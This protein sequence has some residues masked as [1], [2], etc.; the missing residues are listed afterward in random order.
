MSVRQVMYFQLGGREIDEGVEALVVDDLGEVLEVVEAAEVVVE[1]TVVLGVV[2]V[3][4]V[5]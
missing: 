3:L 2:V 1:A 5:V 4:M